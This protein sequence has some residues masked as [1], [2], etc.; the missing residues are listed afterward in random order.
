M[1]PTTL[2]FAVI[3]YLVLVVFVFPRI[4]SRW[5]PRV[6]NYPHLIDVTQPMPETRSLPAPT[7]PAAWGKRRAGGTAAEGVGTR[8]AL[9]LEKCMEER[10]MRPPFM[11]C[12][13]NA[14]GLWCLRVTSD[15]GDEAEL[16]FV[17][18]KAPNLKLPATV[19][20]IDEAGRAACARIGVDD[21]D[22]MTLM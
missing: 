4:A 19:F 20:V 17:H 11:L 22:A 14:D 6:A 12:V 16:L 2:V 13:V 15:E 21:P 9:L 5:L 18:P 7:T 3:S 1:D 8:L 10:G